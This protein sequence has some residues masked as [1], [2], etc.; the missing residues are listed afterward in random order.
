[1]RFLEEK[2]NTFTKE[3]WNSI[4]NEMSGANNRFSWQIINFQSAFKNV[5]NISFVIIENGKPVSVVALAINKNS[6]PNFFGFGN[7]VIPIPLFKKNINNSHRKKIFNYF[8]YKLSEIGKKKKINKVY[9]EVSPIYFENKIAKISSQNQFEL[10]SLTSKF[11]VHNTLIHELKRKTDEQLLN[12]CSKYQRKNIKLVQKKK[13]NFRII[14]HQTDKTTINKET[15]NL[16][17]LHFLSA[18]KATRP[19]KTWDI[20]KQQIF[21]NESDLFALY[22]E[23]TAVS[24][25]YCGR[26][27]NFAWGWTQVNNLDYEKLLMPR[28]LLE[29]KTLLYYKK[30]NVHLYEI[31]ERYFSQKNFKPSKKL[32][33]ISNFK[34]KYGANKYPKVIF[35]LKI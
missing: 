20:M 6:S 29:W 17:K 12:E 7:G 31:G 21:D 34:E 23:D 27:Y 25:L 2:F 32:L 5:D 9:F 8:I 18:K 10:I 35:E 16:Q 19:Q 28:H 11:L 3:Q 24:Y 4:V 33:N 15:K 26:H 1:M 14:N 30:N 22:Y 13:I